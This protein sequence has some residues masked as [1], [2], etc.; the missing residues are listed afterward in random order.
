MR[1]HSL[2]NADETAVHQRKRMERPVVS[3]PL[4]GRLSGNISN[5]LTIGSNFDLMSDGL[6]EHARECLRLQREDHPA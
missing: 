2:R 4:L 1:S 3:H 6:L 5:G